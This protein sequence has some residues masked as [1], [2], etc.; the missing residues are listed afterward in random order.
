MRV[1]TSARTPAASARAA[2]AR[3]SATRR[4]DA[5]D[6][7]AERARAEEVRA[8]WRGGRPPGQRAREAR[9]EAELWMEGV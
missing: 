8:S 7:T 2:S 9:A 1:L 5:A 6:P 4:S 3:A